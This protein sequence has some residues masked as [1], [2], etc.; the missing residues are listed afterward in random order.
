MCCGVW[1]LWV[2]VLAQLLLP[3]GAQSHQAATTSVTSPPKSAPPSATAE[4][5][6]ETLAKLLAGGGSGEQG[7]LLFVSLVA[8]HNGVGM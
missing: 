5:T 3:A 1:R 6:Q 8:P 2:R 4:E 7:K